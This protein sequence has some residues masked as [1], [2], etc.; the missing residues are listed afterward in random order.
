MFEQVLSKTKAAFALGFLVAP[1]WASS[2]KA[3]AAVGAALLATP[4]W[5]SAMELVNYTASTFAVVC[6]AI[7]GGHGVWRIIRGKLKGE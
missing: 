1:L 4:W 7:I 2:A 3:Q 6:G 5:A